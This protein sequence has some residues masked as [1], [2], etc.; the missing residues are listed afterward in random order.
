MEKLLTTED[1]A[2][3]IHLTPEQIRRRVREE[4]GSMPPVVRIGRFLLF[5]PRD[6][7]RW[8]ESHIQGPE[9][10]KSTDNA[11]PSPR[12]RIILPKGGRGNSGGKGRVRDPG[13]PGDP[14]PPH[15]IS[16]VRG[17]CL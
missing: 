16:S 1:L 14:W 15:T 7:E 3:L 13:D 8:I 2:E 9:P 12:K 10:L 6:V 5:R 11:A 4:P 17:K